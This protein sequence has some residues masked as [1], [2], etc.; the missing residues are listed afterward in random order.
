MSL[1]E[2]A[3]GEETSPNKSVR[4]HAFWVPSTRDTQLYSVQTE[5]HLYKAPTIDS[6]IKDV[7][8]SMQI[9]LPGAVTKNEVAKG[10]WF[11]KTTDIPD[12]TIIKFVY[13]RN[14]SITKND[15]SWMYIIMRET[16]AYRRLRAATTGTPNYALKHIDIQGRFDLVQ[17]EELRN[18]GIRVPMQYARF[19][20]PQV[21]KNCFQEEILYPEIQPKETFTEVPLEEGGTVLI[22]R[23]GRIS[24]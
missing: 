11:F 23:G 2:Y 10:R 19:L 6:R 24:R 22:R 18:Y 4:L 16:A 21:R 20:W 7:R 15:A 12:G 3:T 8:S 17:N 5:Q 14:T 1:L 9:A 13:T